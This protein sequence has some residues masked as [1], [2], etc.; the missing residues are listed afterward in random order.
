MCNTN[1]RRSS[2]QIKQKRQATIDIPLLNIDHDSTDG[3]SDLEIT[4]S[5][6]MKIIEEELNSRGQTTLT[7]KTYDSKVSLQKICKEKQEKSK[8]EE[9][10]QNET[11]DT[12]CS[13]VDVSMFDY[14]AI[15]HQNQPTIHKKKV[16]YDKKSICNREPNTEDEEIDVNSS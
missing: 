2:L 10:G 3:E 8:K 4:P 13:D 11:D 15:R 16:A 12:D 14:Y 5:E 7:L 6:F 1:D 9:T